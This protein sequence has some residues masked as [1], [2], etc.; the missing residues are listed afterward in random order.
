ML[1]MINSI[2]GSSLTLMYGDTDSLNYKIVLPNHIDFYKDVL[3]RYSNHFDFSNY[4]P[5]HAL[6]SIINKKALG[7]FSDETPNKF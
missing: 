1:P 7:K 2:P 5:N 4:S 3:P 6:H